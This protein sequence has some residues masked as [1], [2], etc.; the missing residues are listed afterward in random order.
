MT[1]P[2]IF[3]YNSR[4]GYNIRSKKVD[5]LYHLTKYLSFCSLQFV[6]LTG[7]YHPLMFF[8]FTDMVKILL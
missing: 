1:E 8:L 4:A 5:I 6:K 7:L 3:I 2:Q